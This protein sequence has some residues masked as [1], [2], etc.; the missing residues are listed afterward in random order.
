MLES[1]VGAD[2]A[3]TLHSDHTRCTDKR[4]QGCG[5]IIGLGLSVLISL[6]ESSATES[7]RGLDVA[8]KRHPRRFIFT[9]TRKYYWH[10]D[11]LESGVPDVKTSKHKLQKELIWFEIYN[12]TFCWGQNYNQKISVMLTIFGSLM[13][14][15]V[16]Q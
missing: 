3:D 11:S 15:F 16:R 9:T 6:I 12:S 5:F 7:L 2:G 13:C 8:F 4:L 10:V 1:P 14:I